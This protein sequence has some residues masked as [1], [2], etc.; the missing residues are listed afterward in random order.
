VTKHDAKLQQ[1]KTV[2]VNGTRESHDTSVGREQSCTL[3]GTRK[4]GGED[5]DAGW[6]DQWGKRGRGSKF[7]QEVYHGSLRK[8]EITG[9]KSEHYGSLPIVGKNEVKES[10]EGGE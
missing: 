8:G 6:S 3:G 1:I 7:S 2:N 4:T 9:L 5:E 10:R